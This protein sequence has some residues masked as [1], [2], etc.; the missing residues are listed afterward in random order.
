MASEF[1]FLVIGGG[2]IGKRHIANL[3]GLGETA[4]A[5]IDPRADRRAE[6]TRLGIPTYAD[7]AHAW[8]F[9]PNVVLITAPTSLHL[10]LAQQAAEHGC[11]L[12]I[13]K[14][15]ADQLAGIG[16]LIATVE[17]RRLIGLVGCNLRFHPGLTAV[18][19]LLARQVIGKIVSARVEFGQYLPDWHPWEDY[20]TTYSA[21]RD[22]GGGIILDAIHEL[23]YL[24]WLLGEPASVSCLSGKLSRIEID[25]ED[26][27]AMLI[28]FANGIIGEVHLDYVQRTY[29]RE[30]VIVGDQGTI[31]W[32]YRL[33]ETRIFTAA[34]GTWTTFANPTDWNP[35][36][37]YLD[38]LRHFLACLR[39]DADP[40]Q[41]LTEGAAVLGLALTAKQAAE[42]GTV[43]PVPS[44]VA[45][46]G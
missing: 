42:T 46:E 7:L 21:R 9:E 28:R 24:R 14:P 6:L 43:L 44:A 40:M 22:L 33:G 32:D 4:I 34:D 13:E 19:Q 1:R 41:D 23:D 2:S 16:R 37:M 11:H 27:A 25:T 12:F 38:E 20:R 35:N 29:R 31:H 3:Q 15:L 10:P 17:A 26:T 18:R 30:C 39:G 8:A 5:G 36:A 45:Q